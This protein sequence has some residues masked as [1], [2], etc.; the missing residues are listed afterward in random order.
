MLERIANEY[1]AGKDM[2]EIVA[3][4]QTTIH[5]VRV[6]LKRFGVQSR[7][8]GERN[9]RSAQSIDEARLRQLI[10]ER[11][12]TTEIAAL[13]GVTQPTIENKMR[14][15]GLR[16][17]HGHGSPM[18]KNPAWKGGRCFDDDGY[19]LVKVPDHPFAT[20]DGYVREHR[21]VMEE[22]LGRYL[23]PE[24]IVHHRDGNKSNNDPSN[25]RVYESNSHHFLDEHMHHPRCPKTG[26][27]LR[28]Q[29][30]LQRSGHQPVSSN[31][32]E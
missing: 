27:F 14:R 12:S 17:K 11:L 13:M 5:F 28:K 31:H 23:E 4:F 1:R 24:E 8:V 30:D 16:S 26:R 2:H 6:A 20:K 3:D 19:V 10:D 25:L 29:S 21:L 9:R 18:E 22:K 15:L 32:S 7:D